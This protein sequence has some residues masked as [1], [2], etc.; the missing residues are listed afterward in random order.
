MKINSINDSK[1]GADKMFP[2]NKISI[3]EIQSGIEKALKL[4]EKLGAAEAEIVFS[5][6]ESTSIQFKKDIIETAKQSTSAGYGVRAA[7]NG[8]VGFAG[9]N[10]MS[11]L[12][13]TV[14]TAVASAKVMEADP[15][16]RSFP[17][18]SAG[19]K[20]VGG[21]FDDKIV[22][23]S[24]EE[25]IECATDMISG[26][27]SIKNMIPTSGGFSRSV[28][29]F[30]IMNTNG[31][32]AQRKGTAV[33]GFAD[34]TTESGEVSTAYDYDVSRKKDVD[35]TGV[36]RNA[37]DL[38]KKSLKGI[39]CGAEKMPVIFHPFSF[40]DILENTLA[41]SVDAD[42]IQKERSGLVGRLGDEIANSELSII[43]D[44]TLAGG[45]SSGAFDDE[46]TPTQRTSVIEN[47]V[48]KSYLYDS[49]TAGKDGVR[50]TGN[51]YRYSYSSVPSVDFSNFI[52]KF[53][54]S[55]VI[56]ETKKGIYINTVIGA[57]TANEISGDF[58]VEGRNAF[59]I[60]NGEISK[61]I[62]SVMISGN[63]FEMLKKIDGA[64]KDVRSVGGIIT[65]SIRISE[66]SVIGE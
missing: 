46:G 26:V 58:S 2:E 43:D 28:S 11:D 5:I 36:G 22:E 63:I 17:E 38:A 40:A 18:K 65:P 62:K 57:H 49:Y 8:A 59:L 15:F 52:I 9:T 1:N 12:E 32:S 53:P 16:F 39:T 13:N 56:A 47:G 10:L 29:Y 51:G 19:Y 24:L 45:I 3:D 66:M 27:K 41:P 60:E 23:M 14:R 42:N 44:G 7:V 64:G 54:Q 33:S 21:L 35:F 25:C 31:L 20:E 61:P 48:L 34:V 37:A 55:D 50:S 4:S 30:M 6:G